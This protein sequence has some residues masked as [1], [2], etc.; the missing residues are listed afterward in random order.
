MGIFDRFMKSKSNIMLEQLMD[1]EYTQCYFEE[2]K[3]IWKNYVPENGQSDVLQGEL[4]RELEKLRCEVQDNDNIN[5]DENFSCF[6]DF[7]RESLCSQKLFSDK[8]K[9]NLILILNHFKKCGDYAKQWYSGQISDDEVDMDK[10]AYTK[11]N[12]Y[13]M[14]ADAISLFQSK[15]TEPILYEKNKDILT[16]ML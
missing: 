5:W 11:D 13:D 7:I 8:E 14:V 1:E 10:I 15:F 12:L 6:C 3:F 4:L 2:C 9:E 16:E